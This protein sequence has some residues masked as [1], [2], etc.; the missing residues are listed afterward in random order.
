MRRDHVLQGMPRTILKG[1]T[2]LP[3]LF[4]TAR[5][6][7]RTADRMPAAEWYVLEPLEPRVL[8]TAGPLV[9]PTPLL[10][11][12]PLLATTADDAIIA[13]LSLSDDSGAFL[14]RFDRS[15]RPDPTFGDDGVVLLNGVG[16][17]ISLDAR[18]LYPH[19]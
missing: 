5:R 4:G 13:G 16:E 7:A 19:E 17:L 12:V 14:V 3:V 8:M 2:A 6:A 15:G 9:V 11:G 10:T 18:P 1:G